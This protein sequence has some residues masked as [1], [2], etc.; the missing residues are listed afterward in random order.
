MVFVE[1]LDVVLE[2]IGRAIVDRIVDSDTGESLALTHIVYHQYF[3]RGIHSELIVV[4]QVVESLLRT[5]SMY[6]K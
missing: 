2:F 3:A 5:G 1:G 4:Q 6:L